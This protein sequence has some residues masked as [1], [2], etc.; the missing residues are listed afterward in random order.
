MA[1]LKA[2]PSLSSMASLLSKASSSVAVV[3][4]TQINEDSPTIK[5]ILAATG[6]ASVEAFLAYRDTNSSKAPT[7]N[8]SKATAQNA[9][10]GNGSNSAPTNNGT[11]TGSKA[12]PNGAKNGAKVKNGTSNGITATNSKKESQKQV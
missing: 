9:L 8:G 5:R 4:R 3:A 10:S 6:C 12:A 1:N 2:A 11:K 7:H